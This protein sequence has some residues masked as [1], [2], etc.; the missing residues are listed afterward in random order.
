M[1]AGVIAVQFMV[2]AFLAVLTF[3]YFNNFVALTAGRRGPPFA[4]FFISLLHSLLLSAPV[5]L[6][7]GVIWPIR[8]LIVVSAAHAAIFF[9]FL[10]I[11]SITFR[12]GHSSFGD[13]VA[14]A[15]LMVLW[16]ILAFEFAM[17]FIALGRSQTGPGVVFLSTFAALA[18]PLIGGW[19]LGV[20]AWSETLPAKVIESA[21]AM[22][23]SQ[24]YCVDVV[25]RS[26]ES[27][28]DLVAWSMLAP[29]NG[30][31][32]NYFHA[33]MAI[34]YGSERSYANWS[35]RHGRFLPVSERSRAG[36]HLDRFVKCV[37]TEH[38][39]LKL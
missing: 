36:L 4:D 34:G 1:K 12:P 25:G 19:V 9:T 6:V 3:T 39:L 13:S 27:R 7:A 38:F 18:G 22:A 20:L 14:P 2:T 28:R 17:I 24:P 10:T 35:Y 31:Y 30:G 26:V 37:P 33:V 11:V 16:L 8:A 29:K 21:E 5:I 15:I 23:D 32:S